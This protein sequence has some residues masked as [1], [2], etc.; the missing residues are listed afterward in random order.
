MKAG[1]NAWELPDL[2]QKRTIIPSRDG[3]VQFAAQCRCANLLGSRSW[4]R[5]PTPFLIL[6][7]NMHN[8]IATYPVSQS[9]AFTDV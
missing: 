3:P 1:H 5:D 7:A 4:E 6:T 9:E 2:L 8:L